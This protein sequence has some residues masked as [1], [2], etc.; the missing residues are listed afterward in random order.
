[1]GLAGK[2]VG[3]VL[4]TA[5]CGGAIYGALRLAGR[6]LTETAVMSIL[7]TNL[8]G[9][10]SS[11]EIKKFY[12]ETGISPYNAKALK[13]VPLEEQK[14]FVSNYELVYKKK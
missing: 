10:L 5:I 2:I 11:G 12:D 13:S 6:S 4:I 3:G 7:D 14:K 9:K 1:M 8:D